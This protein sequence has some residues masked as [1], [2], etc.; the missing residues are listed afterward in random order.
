MSESSVEIGGN[1]VTITSAGADFRFCTRGEKSCGVLDIWADIEEDTD[2]FLAINGF[3][4]DVCALSELQG[5]TFHLDGERED[6]D[7][8]GDSAAGEL[9][10]SVMGD[11]LDP[12]MFQSISLRFGECV[13]SQIPVALRGVVYNSSAADIPVQ[14]NFRLSINV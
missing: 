11:Y 8:T 14:G 13:D 5:R 3:A 6:A 1:V 10:E 4:V 12:Y 9:M 7:P 2:H